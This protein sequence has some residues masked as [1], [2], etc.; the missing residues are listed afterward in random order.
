M[1]T[2]MEREKF[3]NPGDARALQW[4]VEGFISM[5]GR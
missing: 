1:V 4:G 2:Y 5:V 3:R